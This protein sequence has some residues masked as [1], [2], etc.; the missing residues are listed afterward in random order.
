MPLACKDPAFTLPVCKQANDLRFVDGSTLPCLLNHLE[1][2]LLLLNFKCTGLFLL[3]MSSKAW[4]G[5][6]D[7]YNDF[8]QHPSWQPLYWFLK[9]LRNNKKDRL[10]ELIKTIIPIQQELA[11][12][13]VPPEWRFQS[14]PTLICLFPIAINHERSHTSTCALESLQ[15]KTC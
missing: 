7:V 5:K 4:L 3:Q 1:P 14:R 12:L 15:K 11:S 6:G 2:T 9:Y 10:A 8:R 13:Y